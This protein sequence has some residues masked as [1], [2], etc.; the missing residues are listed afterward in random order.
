MSA[1]PRPR[2]Q[3]A[4]AAAAAA[5]ALPTVRVEPSERLDAVLPW[6]DEF[7]RQVA[8][9]G[10]LN[11]SHVCRIL[12]LYSVSMFHVR[13]GSPPAY[14][15]LSLLLPSPPQPADSAIGHG[16][17]EARRVFTGHGKGK[18]ARSGRGHAGQSGAFVLNGE[19]LLDSIDDI[20]MQA[21]G[22]EACQL[23]GAP[24]VLPL[25]S[26][27]FPPI[28]PPLSLSDHHARP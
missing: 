13:P 1:L 10:K 2:R 20:G 14:L 23:L 25:L 8:Q 12:E 22:G 5:C 21:R 9:N 7:A 18:D 6:A 26:S 24:C 3:L 15:S 27:S 16:E 17:D 28:P 4:S 19:R 11:K